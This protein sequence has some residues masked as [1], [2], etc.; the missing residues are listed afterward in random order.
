M[1]AQCLIFA[2]KML[3]LLE[4]LSLLITNSLA[5][6]IENENEIALKPFSQNFRS[7]KVIAYLN[8]MLDQMATVVAQLV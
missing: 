8:I 3:S 5:I 7:S 6:E 4:S 2:D 1:Q